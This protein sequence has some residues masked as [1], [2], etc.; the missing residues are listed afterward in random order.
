MIQLLTFLIKFCPELLSNSAFRFLNSGTGENAEQGS[1]ILLQSDDVQIYI[2]NEK[3]QIT[4]QIRSLHDPK[5][6]N[7][8]SFDLIAKLLNFEVCT[9]LMD[10]VNSDIL[11]KNLNEII[12]QFEKNNISKT[13]VKLNK[14][15]A[16]RTKKF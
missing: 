13:L 3:E 2:S 7:W 8:F 15:I 1:F 4:W 10:A 11:S 12:N 9:G 16:D 14:L 6:K 5:S